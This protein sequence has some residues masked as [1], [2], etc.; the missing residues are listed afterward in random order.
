MN[1][2]AAVPTSCQVPPQGLYVKLDALVSVCGVPLQPVDHVRG[3]ADVPTE[4][5]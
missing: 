1:D 5:V 3:V 2:M 4:D